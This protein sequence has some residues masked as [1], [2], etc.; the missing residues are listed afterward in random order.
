QT[1]AGSPGW[2]E[3]GGP[4]VK[5]SQG[6]KKL[7]WSETGVQGGT[8][9]LRALPK[10]P[11]I[12]GPFQNIPAYDF[13]AVLDGESVRTPP[14]Y[15]SDCAVIAYRLPAG[16]VNQLQPK[17]TSSDRIDVGLLSDGDLVEYTSLHKASV[18]ERAWIRY[19]FAQPQTL[20]AVNLVLNDPVAASLAHEGD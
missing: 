12:S 7:V 6:M 1:I 4:W 17:V 2:S 18:G 3:S 13:L 14:E 11:T 19:E 10:P 20:H 15:Y 8:P 5:P 16:S 9:L